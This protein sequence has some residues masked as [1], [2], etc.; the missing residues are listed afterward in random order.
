MR[1]KARGS[2]ELHLPVHLA[3]AWAHKTVHLTHVPQRAIYKKA[4][5]SG[6]SEGGES[7]VKSSVRRRSPARTQIRLTYRMLVSVWSYWNLY[8]PL[9]EKGDNPNPWEDCTFLVKHTLTQQLYS[10]V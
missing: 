3:E 2:G 5:L 9:G 10:A 4:H 8:A 7:S 1:L 6:H